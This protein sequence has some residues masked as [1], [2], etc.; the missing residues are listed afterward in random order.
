MKIRQ[1]ADRGYTISRDR[2]F[3]SLFRPLFP[4]HTLSW[5]NNNDIESGL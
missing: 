5:L 4:L 1:S 2:I 3:W